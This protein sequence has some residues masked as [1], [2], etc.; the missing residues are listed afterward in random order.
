MNKIII[1]NVLTTIENGEIRIITS[2]NEMSVTR[3]WYVL[4]VN[5][6]GAVA[7]RSGKQECQKS[8][9]VVMV[10]LQTDRR[11]TH[12]TECMRTHCFCIIIVVVIQQ[13][14]SSYTRII[15]LSV[16]LVI[17]SWPIANDIRIKSADKM[18][19]YSTNKK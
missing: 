9:A 8:R 16:F 19:R 13:F 1:L 10:H 3:V 18:D 4:T 11:R 5:V 12:I 2:L 17:S 14:S 7:Y 15:Y 6:D